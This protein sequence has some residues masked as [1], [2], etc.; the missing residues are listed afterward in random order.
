MSRNLLFIIAG[1]FIAT[2][3]F[4]AVLFAAPQAS[5]P[6]INIPQYLANL[7]GVSNGVG[8]ALH[9]LIGILLAALYVL[10]LKKILP[11]NYLLKGIIYAVILIILFNVIFFPLFHLGMFASLAHYPKRSIFVIIIGYLC[12]GI[13]L[14]LVAKRIEPLPEDPSK[15]S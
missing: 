9:A 10:V 5:L 8:W 7:L 1:G 13:A 2:V 14:A 11:G 6:K 15:L 3:I 4:T 12:Y